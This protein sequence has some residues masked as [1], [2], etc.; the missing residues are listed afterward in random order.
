ML[1]R[2]ALSLLQLPFQSLAVGLLPVQSSHCG[3]AVTLCL[4]QLPLQTLLQES[5]LGEHLPQGCP[6]QPSCADAAKL[7]RSCTTLAGVVTRCL[8]S[9]VACNDD[10][11]QMLCS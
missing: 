11:S 6:M 10:S 4:R 2:P 7:C 8:Q 1:L 3:A 5:G 9:V